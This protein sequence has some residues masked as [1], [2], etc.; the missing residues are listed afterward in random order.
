MDA[1]QRGQQRRAARARTALARD[2][3]GEGGARPG[4]ADVGG[5]P[6]VE[7]VLVPGDRLGGGPGA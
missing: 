3:P 4:R 7:G 5:E 1:E 6:L 2:G